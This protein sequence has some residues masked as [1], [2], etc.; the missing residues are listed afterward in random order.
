MEPV[1]H[2]YAD[3]LVRAGLAERGGVLIGIR[4]AEVAWNREDAAGVVLEKV[5]ADI[6]KRAILFAQPAEPY[7][8]IIDYLAETSGGVIYPQDFET[9]I[10]LQDLPVLPEFNAAAITAA[11]R[12]RR[13]VII[14][15][16]GIV[17]FGKVSPERAFVIF[18]SVCFACFVK[19]FSDT[20][21]HA[22]HN[23]LDSRRR[24]VFRRVVDKLD[25]T[26]AATMMLMKGPFKAEGQIHAAME[27]AG[28]LMVD[29][30]LVDSNFGNIS[31]FSDPV[32]HIS[33]KG[34]ALDELHGGIVPAPLGGLS[35]PP[36]TASTEFPAHREIV[37]RTGIRAVLHG[38]PKFSVI[39][40]MDC[41]KEDCEGRDSCHSRCP[42]KRLIGD[43][44]VVA[45]EAGDG[46]FGLCHTVPPALQDHPGVIVYGHGL[47]TTGRDD[48]NEAFQR[49][50]QIENT[51]RKEYFQRYSGR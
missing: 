19:F 15:G 46:P 22:R 33:R 26:P 21:Y 41:E 48:F 7:K 28:R 32:L 43:V 23:S 20:L 37:L 24:E 4:D 30:R 14:P 16:H 35:A 31:Y 3:K 51:C 44:P 2:K 38:H 12:K 25:P 42:E 9:R 6:D 13:S 11:L 29:C 49:L 5:M 47:F 17:T 8:T 39:L 10:F 45:G 40:S 27:E 50:V 1:I 34:G 18:S 36:E